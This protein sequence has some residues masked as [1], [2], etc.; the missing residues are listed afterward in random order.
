MGGRRKDK[1]LSKVVFESFNSDVY[2]VA[3]YVLSYINCNLRHR[4]QREEAKI[5]AW[6]NLQ[7]AKAEAQSR[8]LEVL[9]SLFSYFFAAYEYS[10]CI[11]VNTPTLKFSLLS[12]LKSVLSLRSPFKSYPVWLEYYY[13]CYVILL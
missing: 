2:I 6:V 8:K 5:Q 7:N 11:C 13:Y 1:M 9:F 3:Y 10:L 12:M 4:Y